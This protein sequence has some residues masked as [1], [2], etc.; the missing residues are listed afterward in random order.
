MRPSESLLVICGKATAVVPQ[1][2]YSYIFKVLASDLLRAEKGM[3]AD[4]TEQQGLAS[5]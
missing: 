5:K 1:P 3:K 2:P 4:N